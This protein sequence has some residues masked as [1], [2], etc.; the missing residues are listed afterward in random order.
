MGSPVNSPTVGIDPSFRRIMRL[1]IPALGALAADPLL[2]LVDTAF[3]GRLGSE[4]L[5]ALAID[6][7]IF[8]FA[9]AAFNFLAYA[10]TPLVAAARGRG[11]VGAAGHVINQ[12]VTLAVFIGVLAGAVLVVAADPLVGLFGPAVE[13]RRMAVDY[14]QVRA[15]AVPALLVVTAGHGAFRGMQDTRTPLWITLVVNGL[16]AILDP[17]LIFS[18]GLGIVGAAGATAIAQWAGA[19]AFLVLLARRGRADGWRLRAVPLRSTRPLMK[20]GGLLILRT[21]LLVSSLAIATAAATSIGTEAAAAHQVISQIYFLVAMIVDAL[22]ITAQAMVGEAW[23]SGGRAASRVISAK[24][25]R[26]GLAVGVALALLLAASQPVLGPLFGLEPEV[27]TLGRQ[28]LLVTA[29]MQPVA[30]LLFVADGVFLGIVA[31]R[32]LAASTAAG[33]LVMALG[34]WAAVQFHAGLTGVWLAMMA[35]VCAR[36]AVLAVGQHR[37]LGRA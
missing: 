10:T 31:I 6:V 32:W 35:M 16:N 14:L 25:Y 15:V 37:L 36:G 9:F 18:G 8:G 28:A 30:A 20:V 5:A 2:S 27:E 34:A 17:L 24:L 21:G 1:A 7:A 26:W 3:V 4:A 19:G 11:E 29:A 13:V 22:A 23:G 12:A 33:F